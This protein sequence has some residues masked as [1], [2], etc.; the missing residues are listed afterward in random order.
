MRAD[1]AGGTGQENR[2]VA[3]F[4][5]VL[6]VGPFGCGS[7]ESW[8]VRG[9]RASSGLPSISGYVQ[10]RKAGMWMLIQY[11]HQSMAEVLY[12]K[13]SRSSATRACESF[14]TLSAMK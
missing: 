13:C 5:P 2:H 11:S 9:G 7:G 1:V 10:R 8:K 3:P 4:V 6:M 12:P 14:S